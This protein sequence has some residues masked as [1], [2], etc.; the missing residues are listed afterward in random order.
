[1]F[2]CLYVYMYTFSELDVLT[3][4][5]NAILI[6]SRRT[7]CRFRSADI[8]VFQDRAFIRKLRRK[9]QKL[10]CKL[11][12]NKKNEEDNHLKVKPDVRFRGILQHCWEYCNFDCEIALSKLQVEIHN[13]I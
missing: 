13:Q 8:K 7:V 2:I 3:I 11:D 10:T 12:Q 6:S 1:M 5:Y 9:S 4:I